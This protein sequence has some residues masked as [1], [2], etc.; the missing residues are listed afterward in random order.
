VTAQRR[1]RWAVAGVGRHT[2][3]YLLPAIAESARGELA[4]LVTS[5]PESAARF[6]EPWGR[7]RIHTAL[8]D[9]L[10]D[11]DIDGVMLATPNHVH[12]DQVL[13]AAHAGKHVLCEKPLATT[14]ADAAEMVR[15]C[16]QNGVTLGTG[17]HLRHNLVHRTARDMIR[18]G[19]IG[20]IRFGSVRY[21]HRT[22]P[23]PM[24]VS[25]ARADIP[26]VA[27][28]RRDPAIAG[29]GAFVSTGSHAIDLLRFLTDAEILD[30]QARGDGAPL[31]ESTLGFVGSLDN[32]AVAMIHAGELSF[33]E[34]ET[35]ISGTEGTV[36]CRG[37]VGN[38]GQG[39][40]TLTTA[41]GIETFT[42][43]PHNVYVAQ[44]DAFV[45]AVAGG[46]DADASGIDGLRAQEVI[47]A[48][49]TSADNAGRVTVTHRLHS[50]ETETSNP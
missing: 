48:A 12:R 46:F 11:P 7:P 34:N 40:L 44:C 50:P 2:R 27:Q 41:A 39:T 24:G 28:W 35:T 23:Q 29:G 15:V 45:H 9:A 42:P 16:Q 21:S 47:D 43:A 38:L 26:P 22:A 13:A 10:A 20:Q 32:G 25:T 30:V 8:A 14:T 1:F 19:R 33:P 37:S 49:Y 18:A 31:Q 6:A 36:V 5:D 3:Q 17:F 4:A